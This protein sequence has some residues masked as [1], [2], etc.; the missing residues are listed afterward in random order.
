MRKKTLVALDPTG[1]NGAIRH[2]DRI[3][4]RTLR[5]RYKQL[6]TKYKKQGVNIAQAYRSEKKYLTS[7]EF[8]NKYLGL[9]QD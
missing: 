1:E 4:Y 5:D 7:E 2:I 6:M 8:W 3:T 9:N